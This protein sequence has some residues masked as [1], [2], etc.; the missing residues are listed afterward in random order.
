MPMNQIQF[1]R[2]VSEPERN[3]NAGLQ[4]TLHTAFR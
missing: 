2:G 1:Q 3:G 4:V